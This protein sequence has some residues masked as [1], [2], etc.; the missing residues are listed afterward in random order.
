MACRSAPD[1]HRQGAVA[2]GQ[3]L[4]MSRV[5]AIPKGQAL[6][7]ILL[8]YFGASQLPIALNEYSLVGLREA[9]NQVQANNPTTRPA[10]RTKKALIEYITAHIGR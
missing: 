8:E 9:A 6:T 3:V 5:T 7:L 1:D 2:I 4:R 10:G